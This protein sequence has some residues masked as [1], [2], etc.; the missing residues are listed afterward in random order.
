MQCYGVPRALPSS[1]AADGSWDVAVRRGEP[2]LCLPVAPAVS[3]GF[4]RQII[5]GSCPSGVRSH[6]VLILILF[7]KKQD[8]GGQK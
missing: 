3:V 4:P 2:S 6:K 1:M 7:S 5:S 8:G